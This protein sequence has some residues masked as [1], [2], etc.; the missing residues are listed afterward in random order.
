MSNT[1]F[2]IGSSFS[3]EG[4]FLKGTFLEILNKKVF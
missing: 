3:Y 4:M 2:I 1:L